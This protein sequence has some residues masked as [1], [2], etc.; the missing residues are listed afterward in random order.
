MKKSLFIADR[1]HLVTL[2]PDFCKGRA[3]DRIYSSIRETPN[4]GEVLHCPKFSIFKPFDFK[5]MS[6]Q[7]IEHVIK[8]IKCPEM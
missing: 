4:G 2:N 6:Y 7:E 1:L 8:N 5:N 3:C